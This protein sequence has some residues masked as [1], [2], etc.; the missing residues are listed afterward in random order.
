MGVEHGE[1]LLRTVVLAD[2]ADAEAFDQGQQYCRGSEWF[3][4]GGDDAVRLG[5][6]DQLSEMGSELDPGSRRHRPGGHA[7]DVVTGAGPGQGER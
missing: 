7:P 3:D 6:S 1:S 4:V 2:H 5:D